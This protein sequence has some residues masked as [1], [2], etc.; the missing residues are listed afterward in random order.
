[1]SQRRLPR[2]ARK[3][4]KDFGVCDAGGGNM[5][6]AIE[7]QKNWSLYV[8]ELQSMARRLLAREGGRSSLQLT[9]LIDTA[10]RRQPRSG[11]DWKEVSWETREHFFADMHQAMERALIDHARR[12]ASKKR[13]GGPRVSIDNMSNEDHK[14]VAVFQPQDIERCFVEDP[15]V[16]GCLGAAMTKL[17]NQNPRLAQVV[18]YRIFS[19][20]TT[21]ETAGMIGMSRSTVEKDWALAR[22]LLTDD[23]SHCLRHG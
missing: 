12:R 19:G 7:L 1:M 13:Q 21:E 14:R 20:L 16:L 4:P 23:I 18:D 17:R 5:I 10:M 15:E 3:D 9:E 2:G 11:K 8:E 6:D 22:A